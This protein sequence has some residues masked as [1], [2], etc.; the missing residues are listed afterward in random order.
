MPHVMTVRGA[1]DPAE[2]G[3]TLTHEHIFMDARGRWDPSDLADPSLGDKPFAPEFGAASRFSWQAFRD[4][5][6]QLPD[7]DYDLIRDEVREFKD[8]GGS[9]IVE[10]TIDGIGP[11]PLALRKI[12]TELDLHV[13]VGCGWYV[14]D[15]HPA[16]IES[17][18]VEE[19]AERLGDTVAEGIDGTD[20]RPGIIGEI[21]TSEQL[22]P[23]E[24]RVLRAS[25]RVARAT[26]L[27]INIHCNPPALDV[28]VRILDVLEEEGHP[29][30]RTSLSHLDEI[31]DLSYHETVL[32]RGS[33]TGF[34]S[35]GHEG[36]YFTPTW[37]SRSDLEKMTT[38]AA[39]VERG[40]EDQ[41]VLSQDMHR[42]HFLHRFGGYGYDHVLRRI[43]PRLRGSLGVG[44]AA[45]EKM[46]VTNPRRLLTIDEPS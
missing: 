18:S 43:V 2:I 35:F 11:A 12:S 33:L 37:R 19:I 7:E 38:V 23:C 29:L 40:Y 3:K 45:I 15:L 32:K 16:W 14:H 17:A 10:L 13:V 8:A 31:E 4:S 26:G 46:L 39:L 36:G 42:K 28:V 25:A 24:E 20:V 22:E 9:C 44:E 41:L 34:D 6:C 21:G 30:P 1:V 27:P 5:M